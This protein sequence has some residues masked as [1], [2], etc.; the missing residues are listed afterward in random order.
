MLDEQTRA[1][2]R[3]M[4]GLRLDEPLRV[5]DVEGSLDS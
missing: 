5:A 4:L 3:L 1:G 2:E